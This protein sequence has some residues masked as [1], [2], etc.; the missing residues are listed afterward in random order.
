M[1]KKFDN[2]SKY[3]KDLKETLLKENP[4]NQKVHLDTKDTRVTKS[5]KRTYISKEYC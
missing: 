3:Y 2:E 5:R 4:V 1:F